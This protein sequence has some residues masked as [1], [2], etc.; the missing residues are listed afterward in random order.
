MSAVSEG[1]VHGRHGGEH[2]WPARWLSFHPGPQAADR[3][4]GTVLL[5]EAPEPAPCGIPPPNGLSLLI[6]PTTETKDASV[7]T[8]GPLFQ[9][10]TLL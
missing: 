6:L 5:S 2:W 3:E 9:T 1:S 7:G 8:C 10:T 4:L